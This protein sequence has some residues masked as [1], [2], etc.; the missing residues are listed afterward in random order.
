MRF[1]LILLS[2]VVLACT[3][4]PLEHEAVTIQGSDITRPTPDPGPDLEVLRQV[5]SDLNDAVNAEDLEKLLSLVTEDAVWMPPN[6]PP[7]VGREAI[8]HFYQGTFEKYTVDAIVTDEV[9]KVC[10]GLWAFARVVVK[11]S[12]TPRTGGE[13]QQFE[14]SGMG[15][16]QKQ[17]G[18]S[19]R[20]A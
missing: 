13:A 2:L 16:F 18:G 11:G 19:E 15:I 10:H 1:Q 8:R 4:S 9:Q 3:G 17:F 5:R 12:L 6:H 7:L 14:E 20:G